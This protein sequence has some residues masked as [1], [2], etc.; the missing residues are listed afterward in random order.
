MAHE[1]FAQADCGEKQPPQAISLM[2]PSEAETSSASAA[3]QGLQD[4][5]RNSGAAGHLV[6]TPL[7]AFETD[8]PVH[9][10]VEYA[11][12]TTPL[13]NAAITLRNAARRGT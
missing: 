2:F 3:R 1:S 7:W 10:A 6:C 9:A 12:P 11:G 8:P 5:V 4:T 13:Q